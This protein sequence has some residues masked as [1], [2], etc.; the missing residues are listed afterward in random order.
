MNV[1]TIG[2]DIAKSVFQVHGEDC[3]GKVVIRKRLGQGDDGV[4]RERAARVWLRSRPAAVILL[5][6]HAAGAGH[7]VRLIPAAYVKPFVKRNKTD[8][9]DAAAICLAARRPDMR[10]V[11][12]KSEAQQAS[13]ALKRSRELLVRQPTQL[14]NSLR[15]MLAEFGVVATQRLRGFTELRERL[16]DGEGLPETRGRHAAPLGR[17]ARQPDAGDRGARGPDQSGRQG[18]SDDAAV[19]R[20]PRRRLS[21]RPRG[22]GRDAAATS[23]PGPA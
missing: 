11:A 19:V 3:E 15:A 2:V 18:R 1:S 20:R 5:G 9:R 21:D 14:M 23:L 12:V 17:P 4:L 16:A 8:A 22:R 7:E 6:P 13:R 10:P